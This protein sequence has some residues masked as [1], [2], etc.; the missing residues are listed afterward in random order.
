MSK[1]FTYLIAAILTLG[2]Q[3][4]SAKYNIYPEQHA[5]WGGN[6]GWWGGG[7]QNF[8]DDYA[9]RHED[10]EDRRCPHHHVCHR[11]GCCYPVG[12]YPP[13]RS[14][15]PTNEYEYNDTVPGAGLYLDLKR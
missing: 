9:W 12:Y 14:A 1:S 10:R 3:E 4:V 13:S 15:N 8:Y 2:L 6:G 7:N 11:C 5:A